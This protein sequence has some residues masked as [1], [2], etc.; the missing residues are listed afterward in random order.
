MEEVKKEGEE[1]KK[2]NE[3]NEKSLYVNQYTKKDKQQERD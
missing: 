2:T 3:M 1:K